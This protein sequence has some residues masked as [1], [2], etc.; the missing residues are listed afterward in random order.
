MFRTIK[1][2]ALAALLTGVAQADP[3]ADY[4]GTTLVVNFPAHPH[5][6]AVMRILPE[7]TE[8]T[9]IEVEV[10]E[11]QYLRMRDAQLLEMS[12]PEGDYDLI[13]SVVFWKTQ[14]ADKRLVERLYAH[15]QCTAPDR[16]IR[17]SD[18]RAEAGTVLELS[19]L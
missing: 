6:D 12:K 10:D 1:G 19:Q 3:Y 16:E 5:Y 7:F 18:N 4:E 9:G 14:Y 11:L 17:R 15:E 2:A 8:E 13:S